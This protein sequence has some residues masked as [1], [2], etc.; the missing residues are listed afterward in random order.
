M[1]FTP[2]AITYLCMASALLSLDASNAFQSNAARWSSRPPSSLSATLFSVSSNHVVDKTTGEIRE[3]QGSSATAVLERNRREEVIALDS[4]KEETDEEEGSDPGIVSGVKMIDGATAKT[5]KKSITSKEL[6]SSGVNSAVDQV[7][8]DRNK[9]METNSLD[10]GGV[11]FTDRIANSGAASTAALATAAVNAAVAMKSLEAPDVSKSYISLDKTSNELD[12]DGL[13]LVYD[14]DLIEKYWRKERGA[15]NQRWSY[16]VSKAVPFLTKMVSLFIAEGKIDER[17]IPG[18]SRQARVDLQDLG[19]TFIKAGQMMS[20]RPDVLPQST[21]DELT[22]LQDSVVPFDTSI[23]VEQIEAELGGP[24]GQF[25][26]SISE[27]PVAA[28]S[29]AQVYLATLNDGKNTRVAVKVQRPDV[30]STV[31]KDLYVLRRAAEV[32]QGLVERFAPQQKTNYV[33]LLNE[34]A[35]GFYTELDFANEARNQK[36]LREALERNSIEGVTVPRVYD[37]LCTRRI[38]VSEW[39][40]GKKLSECPEEEISVITDMC[41]EAFLVQLFEEGFFHADPHPGNILKLNQ[42]TEEGHTVALIDCGLMASIEQTDRDNMISA[43]IHL[44]NKDY[45]SLVDDFIQLNILPPDSDRAAIIPLMDKALSPYVKGGG[46]KKYE[47][48]LKKLYGMEEGSMQSQV[49]GFQAMTQDALTVLNDVPFSIPPYFAILGRAIVTLEGI[50]LTG[51]P[52]YGIIMESYPFIARKLL[53]EDRPEIQRALQEVLYSS[54]EA[55]GEGKLKFTRLLALLNN[56]AGS[57]ETQEGAAFVDLDAVPDSGLE[58]ADGLKFLLSDKAESLRNLLED[59]VDSIVDILTRQVLRK[60][61]SEAIVALTPPRPPALPF[62]GNVFPPPPKLDNVPL[63]F[64]L[65]SLDGS[66]GAPSVALLTVKD[67]TDLIAPSLNQDEEI[68]AIGLA[69]AA[70]EFFGQDVAEFVRGDSVLSVQSAQ[71]VLGAVRSGLTGQ[72]NALNDSSVQSVLQAVGNLINGLGSATG[73]RGTLEQTLTAAVSQL[74]ESERARLDDIVSELVRR[75]ISRAT[76]RL[77][78]VPRTL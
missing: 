31:S 62:L 9:Q 52:D 60:G 16:F 18:L 70:G 54:N 58:F 35:I 59:E 21:L 50:A 40:D 7:N 5:M 49:G 32:F 25:F 67:F 12:E 22:K 30:L 47:E 6:E 19:P 78:S 41:Q 15:L 42:P 8:D 14:K 1:K 28:A 45:A 11:S 71:M 68:Y 13:P 29:L 27:E 64:L 26:T 61:L 77:S 72:N 37:E 56:A 3:G 23:A 46:A 51:N 55:A 63:P 34:W 57:I 73:S 65:P 48:E 10:N 2:G 53:R 4:D 74:S 39:M 36:R 17:H 33:A 44:A 20:V 24:L 38:L 75:S 76:D 69:E 66:R 43:V